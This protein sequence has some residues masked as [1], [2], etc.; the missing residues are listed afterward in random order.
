MSMPIEGRLRT[1]E[2]EVKSLT[3]RVGNVEKAQEIDRLQ[4]DNIAGDTAETKGIA[5]RILWLIV[6]G[7][8]TFGV[9]LLVAI[10]VAAIKLQGG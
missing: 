4:M 1:V 6:G 9:S 10:I 7:A 8:V 3:G 2:G 5:M